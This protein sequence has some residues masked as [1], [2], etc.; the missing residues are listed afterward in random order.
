[1][2]DVITR[3]KVD[4]HEYDAKVKR[5][6]EGLT[7]YEKKCRDVGGTL[8]YV[9]K[10]EL[11]FVRSLG[12]MDTVASSVKGKVNELKQAYVQ[13]AVQYKNLTD[14]EKNAP[15][16]KALSQSLQE[17][18]GR[19]QATNTQIRSAEGELNGGFRSAVESVA[20]KLG[21]PTQLLTKM[22]AGMAAAGA[23]AKVATDAF[24]SNELAM[25]EWGR[26]V[27]A[28]GGLYQGFLSALN[29]TTS[30]SSFL[31]NIGDIVRAARDAYDALDDL[32]TF[33]AFNQINMGRT[34]ADFSNAIVDLREGKID[35]AQ[36]N[37]KKQAY[38]EQLE[39]RKKYEQQAYEAA[40]KKLA[41]ERDVSADDLM[42]A[43]SGEW[44]NYESLKALPL[45]KKVYTNSTSTS[46]MGGGFG[47]AYAQAHGG[48]RD[49]TYE[50]ANDAEHLGD[51]LRKLNDTEIQDI[52]SLGAAA[53][54][55]ELA[56]AQIER[57]A[58]RY[59]G[60]TATQTTTAATTAAKEQ[61]R[62]LGIL[63][64]LNREQARLNKEMNYAQ[65]AK[66]VHQLAE[67]LKLV[68]ER[69]DL[70][71]NGS[72]LQ[73]LASGVGPATPVS[74]SD[75]QIQ[76]AGTGGNNIAKMGD[77]AAAAW[78]NAASA[79]SNVGSALQNIED[80]A[81]KVTGIVL[82]AV[83]NIALGFAQAAASPAT[84]AAGVFG[85]IAAATA[86]LATMTA[87][88]ASIKSV[89]KGYATGGSVTGYLGKLPGNP[90][91]GDNVVAR[92][93]MGEG[94]LTRQGIANATAMMNGG[95]APIAVNVSGRISGRDILLAADADNRSRGGSRYA[96][97]SVK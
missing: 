81:A 39:Q 91:M 83:A 43:L 30:F 55:T 45:S 79:V 46:I 25:D 59:G 50:A 1:M 53:Q 3:L 37:E 5:A 86:G 97:S 80:P 71:N 68:K 13:L 62:Q 82:Q 49:Y 42:N 92:L 72:K 85:W 58:Q 60:S 78:R 61:E 27:E 70:I 95:A 66:E 64:E 8:E 40:V 88:I 19:I 2:G 96:Y 18:K 74:A 36:F 63:G 93:N 56:I 41:A 51:V 12:K 28:A 84:G 94:V 47:D 6:A 16:G 33:N 11:D 75:V 32:G 34:Q 57:Q 67:E 23:A 73:P 24:K 35:K 10:Q 15:Y 44:G 17:L 22:G 9:E 20:G 69:I 48:L 87:T 52:Q 77:A 90:Y 29:G 26:T 54:Q 31:S 89:T 14:A 76:L 38:I 7:Q 21:L 4:S 65:S